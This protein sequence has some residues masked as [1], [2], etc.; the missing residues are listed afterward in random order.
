MKFT[1]IIFLLQATIILV[2]LMTFWEKAKDCFP[3]K[4]E[5]LKLVS[6][7]YFVYLAKV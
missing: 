3:V 6:Y 5:K 7:Y 1:L 2:Q 4:F